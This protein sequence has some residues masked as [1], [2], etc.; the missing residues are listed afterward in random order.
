[1]IVDTAPVKRLVADSWPKYGFLRLL[2]FPEAFG[3]N[4]SVNGQCLAARWP[5]VV[6]GFDAQLEREAD[7]LG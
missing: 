5:S 4:G 6:S 1:M 2:E 3:A 7:S